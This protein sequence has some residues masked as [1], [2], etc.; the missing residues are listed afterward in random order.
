MLDLKIFSTAWI[1]DLALL[2]LAAH[3]GFLNDCRADD[4]AIGHFGSTDYGDWTA[5]GSAFNAGPAADDHFFQL[6]I[7]DTRDHQV[8]NSRVARSAAWPRNSGTAIDS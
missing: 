5:K 3:F 4:L 8:A 6:G 2:V 7:H 1:P